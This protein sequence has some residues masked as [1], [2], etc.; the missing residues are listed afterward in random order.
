MRKLPYRENWCSN[1]HQCTNDMANSSEK[2]LK[3]NSSLCT[4]MRASCYQFVTRD[5]FCKN[6]IENNLIISHPISGFNFH[7]LYL[8]V[9]QH[10]K[11]IV[12]PLSSH[13]HIEHICCCTFLSYKVQFISQIDAQMVQFNPIH[14]V[15]DPFQRQQQKRFNRIGLTI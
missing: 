10:L 7:I 5:T 9:K 2:A 15:Q 11:Y 12:W 6:S 14:E 4:K 1:A 13:V 8:Q 3:E